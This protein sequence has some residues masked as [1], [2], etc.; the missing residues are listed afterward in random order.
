MRATP[1]RSVS[2]GRRLRNSRHFFLFASAGPFVWQ[3]HGRGRPLRS[4]RYS[5]PE[6]YTTMKRKLSLERLETKETPSGGGTVVPP[7]IYL[8]AAGTLSVYGDEKDQIVSV[9]NGA[10]S[11]VHASLGHVTYVPDG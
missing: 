4:V 10:D 8:N 1:A 9:W 11:L 5:P 6:R 7:G 3:C 2:A